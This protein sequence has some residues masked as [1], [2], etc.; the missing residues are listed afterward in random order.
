[1]LNQFKAVA[2]AGFLVAKAEFNR[3]AT[4]V[5]DWFVGEMT[6]EQVASHEAWAA[7]KHGYIKQPQ[8][9]VADFF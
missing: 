3:F 6:E 7:Q 2:E 1:M 4:K 9:R 8:A 5:A